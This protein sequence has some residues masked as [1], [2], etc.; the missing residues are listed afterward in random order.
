M[1]AHHS[2]CHKQFC[3]Q[4]HEARRRP[5]P[6]LAHA[7][8]ESGVSGVAQPSD[9]AGN[10][11]MAWQQEAVAPPPAFAEPFHPVNMA[12]RAMLDQVQRSLSSYAMSYERCRDMRPHLLLALASTTLIMCPHACSIVKFCRMVA[13]FIQARSR[14]HQPLSVLFVGCNITMIRAYP[15][16]NPMASVLGAQQL[17]SM[18]WPGQQGWGGVPGWGAGNAAGMWPSATVA[19]YPQPAPGFGGMANPQP[20]ATPPAHFGGA[21][22]GAQPGLAGLGYM[23]NQAQ[24][25][26]LQPGGVLMAAAQFQP[27]YAGLQHIPGVDAS[28][29][30]TGILAQPP[31]LPPQPQQQ[32]QR[33]RP[34]TP[35]LCAP[36]AVFGTG[37]APEAA[38]A[39]AADAREKGVASPEPRP[40]A[41]TAPAVMKEP[42][43][44]GRRRRSHPGGSSKTASE[45]RVAPEVATN[46]AGRS[47]SAKVTTRGQRQASLSTEG[48]GEAAGTGAAS[49]SPQEKLQLSQAGRAQAAQR[50]QQQQKGTKRQRRSPVAPASV[51]AAVSQEAQ[52]AMA[53]EKPPQEVGRSAA[54]AAR[55]NDDAERLQQEAARQP[56]PQDGSAPPQQRESS[57][58]APLAQA[59][60]ESALVAAANL[61]AGQG[62]SSAA[63]SLQRPASA[64]A[65]QQQFA[66]YQ[67]QFLQ[68]QLAQQQQQQV[69]AVALV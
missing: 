51:P 58:V 20:A 2:P 56:Q 33:P 47:A 60:V 35:P 44:V 41:A 27:G 40:E 32:R 48:A 66:L 14:V 7:P 61:S 8:S 67:Q 39:A 23:P 30:G 16:V 57:S 25:P 11:Q 18:G 34:G 24:A 36:P 12:R 29:V 68:Q 43:A 49:Q 65:S 59:A 10:G 5:C 46:R 21:A 31:N 19:G 15:Q 38:A 55:R 42:A 4:F 28:F 9:G 45:D 69:N 13:I 63:G 50:Q 3:S 26:F 62:L 64:A 6:E 53:A 52:A 54:A 37:L 17:F 22:G 1:R